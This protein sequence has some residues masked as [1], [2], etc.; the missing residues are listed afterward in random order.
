M[1]IRITLVVL[2]TIMSVTMLFQDKPK[3]R[4]VHLP[5]TVQERLDN[6]NRR[7]EW[8]EEAVAD[9]DRPDLRDLLDATVEARG[10]LSRSH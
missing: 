6:L 9:G 1:L 2:V 4:I 5:P 8:L 3:G 10:R 7:I